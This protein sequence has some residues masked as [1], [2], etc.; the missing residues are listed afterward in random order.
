MAWNRYLQGRRAHGRHG[1]LPPDPA[2]FPAEAQEQK[3]RLESI[4]ALPAN[5]ESGDWQW[6]F[7]P[8]ALDLDTPI[9]EFLLHELGSLDR[10]LQAVTADRP[11]LEEYIRELEDQVRELNQKMQSKRE[12]LAAAIAA[13]ATIA[14]MGNRNDAAAKTVGRISY[15]F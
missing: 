13:N 12:E 15:F 6:P 7:A 11:H 2:H 14:A 3:S 10:E 5:P 1:P 8:E 9:G 4:R